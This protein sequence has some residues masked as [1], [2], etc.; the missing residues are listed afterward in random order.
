MRGLLYSGFSEHCSEQVSRTVDV[1]EVKV[2]A[3]E[4]VSALATVMGVEHY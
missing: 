3:C 4:Q 2:V 1:V